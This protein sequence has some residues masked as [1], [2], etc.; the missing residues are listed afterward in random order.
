MSWYQA[1]AKEGGI[2]YVRKLAEERVAIAM[3]DDEVNVTII[4]REAAAERFNLRG[5]ADQ[6]T[7]ER[8]NRLIEEIIK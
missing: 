8:I 1:T 3:F 5:R 4:P 7:A 6:L 2:A